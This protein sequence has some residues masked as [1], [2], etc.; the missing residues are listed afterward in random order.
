MREQEGL[1]DAELKKYLIDNQSLLWLECERI[2]VFARKMSVLAVPQ[3][4]VPDLLALVHCQ[5]GH[6]GVARTLSLL[7]DRFHWPGIG[8][9]T[10]NYV[11]SCGCRRRKRSRR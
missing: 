10:R 5:H 4:S 11:C 8:R 6:L 9:H 2:G 7:R 1:T 3:C